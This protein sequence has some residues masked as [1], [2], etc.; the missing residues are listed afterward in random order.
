M[1]G[2]VFRG[3]DRSAVEGVRRAPPRRTASYTAV[4]A[5]A[6]LILPEGSERFVQFTVLTLASLTTA[7][8]SWLEMRRARELWQHERE[9]YYAL[10]DVLRE[11]DFYEAM[12]AMTPE[13]VE[14][15][16]RQAASILG[17]S[18][19]KWA[20]IQQKRLEEGGQG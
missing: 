8:T 2:S 3:P 7:V 17:S 9:V 6:G 14:A 12:G 20:R 18:S 1:P 4:V 10:K 16:F 13:K 11:V 15:Y 5:G 19:Q